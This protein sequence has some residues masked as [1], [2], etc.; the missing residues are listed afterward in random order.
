M[1][2]IGILAA[3]LLTFL[4]IKTQR[5]IIYT[6]SHQKAEL[7]GNMIENR[8]YPWMKDGKQEKVQQALLEIANSKDIKNIRIVSTEGEILRS[9]QEDEI[10]RKVEN[11]TLDKLNTFLAK[12]LQ[13]NT[14]SIQEKSTIQEFRIIKN[15]ELCFECHS[16][17]EKINGILEIDIDFASSA[18]L[19][20]RSQFQGIL[21]GLIALVTL[22]FVIVRLFDKL[23]NRP[24][25]QLKNRMETVQEGNLNI[26]LPTEKNDEI[27][28]LTQS[29]NRMT[30]KLK[31]ANNKIEKLYNTQM[32]KAGHLASI[33][34]LAAGLAHEIRNPVAGIKGALE[35]I[36]QK[37]ETS[38]PKIEIFE[39]MLLQIEKIHNVILDL[40]S[41]ARPREMNMSFINPNTPIE[42]AINLAKTQTNKK[43]IY[44]DFKGLENGTRFLM[45]P[46]KIQEVMLNMMLNSIS[47]IR[48]KGKITVELRNDQNNNLK[49][50]FS[51]DGKG[52]KKGNMPYIFEPFFTTKKR[53]TGLGLSI[54]KKIIEAHK[55]AIK[56]QSKENEGTTFYI[57]L[58]LL[59]P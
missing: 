31:E 25:S 26:Q 19:L 47:A 36:H 11:Q 22:T 16:A 28:K 43:D 21:I 1:V 13:E 41:Y 8:L 34:E 45:D 7:L 29:F 40:L 38:D 51:D 50:I 24:I 57:Q 54:C 52:I 56:V 46:N 2:V 14:T 39:E 30:R 5:N 59:K 49:I 32:E 58:P 3:F 33:G 23:I 6:M 20:R 37:T 17:Q 4:Y 42:N 12:T 44:F 27:G 10:G 15:S 53:G 18:T 55:G 9:S 48:K 35:I